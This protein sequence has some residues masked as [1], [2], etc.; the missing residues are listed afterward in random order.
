M[1]DAILTSGGQTLSAVPKRTETQFALVWR[2]FRR[3]KS[4]LAGAIALALLALACIFVPMFTSFKVD[5]VNP[6]Q[7][8]AH[9]GEADLLKGGTHWLGTDWLGRDYLTRL[10]V[11]GR[12]SLFVA[13]ASTLLMVLIGSLVDGVAGYFGG[14]IDTVIMRFTDL[15]LALPLLPLFLLTLRLLRQLMVFMPLWQSP[16]TSVYMTL[17]VISLVFTLF[18]W[19]GLARLV[20]GSILSLRT[21]PFIEA[22][23]ALGA[24]RRRVIFRHLLPNTIAPI[25]VAATFAVGDFII[26]EAVLAYF[27]QGIYDPPLVSWGNLLASTV[28]LSYS[29]TWKLT[30]ATRHYCLRV[31]VRT[32]IMQD[33]SGLLHETLV[34]RK[35]IL[36]VSY[37]ATLMAYG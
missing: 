17:G 30:N 8:Y 33:V 13:L 6:V 16:S 3:Q 5:E 1:A 4:A 18:G 22:A 35:S 7:G 36:G 27:N 15:L 11:G 23:R 32:L 10:L 19:M 20:R 24:R 29:I 25:L 9:F 34:Q 21:Q 28:S 14:L 12:T 2:R 31:V 37:S 26:L